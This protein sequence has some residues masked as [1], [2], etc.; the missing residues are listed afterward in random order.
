MK[1]DTGIYPQLLNPIEE[2]E[3]EKYLLDDD[4]GAQEK[5]DGWRRFLKHGEKNTVAINRKGEEVGCSI[6]Y[7]NACI[8][9]NQKG[10]DKFILDGEEVSRFLYVFDAV[11]LDGKDLYNF[12]YIDRYTFLKGFMEDNES[13]TLK[14]LPLAIG[15]KAKKALYEKLKKEGK[16]GIVF[17]KLSAPYQEGRPEKYGDQV[18]FKFYETA[19][20][21]VIRINKKRSIG[22]GMLDG[23]RIIDVGNC[24]IPPNKDVPVLESI[25]EIKYLYAYKGGS[26]YQPTYIG[27]RDD[28]DRKDC[29]ISQLKY[30]AEETDDDTKHR[31]YVVWGDQ[32]IV[33][34]EYEFDTEKEKDAFVYGINEADGYMGAIIYDKKE[35]WELVK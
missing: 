21:I 19:S 10:R 12:P 11:Y 16:E 5:K 32:K 18:K 2:K 6:D 20:C 3:V 29:V 26:L 35:D 25:V 31:V 4:Y 34:S 27:P 23:D 33:K 30:K 28:I 7:Q 17:K 22:L 24:T 9:L 8:T 15:Y 14:L 13:D 1:I